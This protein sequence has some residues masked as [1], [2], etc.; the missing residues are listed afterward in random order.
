LA[1]LCIL[2]HKPFVIGITGSFGKTTARHI[3][4]EI[5]KRGHQ[6]VWTP[7]W[8][9]NGEWGLALSVLQIR[10]GGRSILGWFKALSGALKS[11][12]TSW[13]PSTL[14]LEYGIDHRG[15]MKIQT[16]IVEPD[17]ALFTTLS[18]SHLQGFASVAEYYAEKW[19]LLSRK[20]KHTFAI[21]NKDDMNQSGF[22]CQMWYGEK[23]T[24]IT[25]SDIQEYCEKTEAQIHIGGN[26]S[27]LQTSILGKHHIGLIVGAISVALQRNMVLP[28][29]LQALESI[30]LPE[31]RGNVLRGISDSLVIDG[32][33]NGGFEPIIAGV[34]MAYRLAQAEDRKL[35]TL[36]WDMRELWTEETARH[37]ELW[38]TLRTLE[39]IEYIFVGKV[40]QTVI[41]PMLSVEEGKRVAFFLDARAAGE[42]ARERIFAC[43]KKVLVFA[44]WS[45]NTIYLEEAVK[46]IIL[47]EEMNKIVRQDAMYLEK[48]QAFWKTLSQ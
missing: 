48:K 27:Y 3:V 24:D 47:S 38:N 29:I 31:G 25:F 4:T 35:I 7:E 28:E 10:S 8:N 17:I 43:D 23:D 9:Y 6:D 26:T 41:S 46:E 1:R 36:I 37:Q 18:P 34:Q 30:H 15:E 16:D 20:K 12:L 40:C 13:Y 45:Q 21:G 2:R 22:D 11:I 39:N 32:T 19:K 5:I 42:R 44:K 14:I 33:Y